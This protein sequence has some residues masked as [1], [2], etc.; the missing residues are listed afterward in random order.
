MSVVLAVLLVNVLFPLEVF[1]A[2]G[3]LF[4]VE[5]AAEFELLFGGRDSVIVT[6]T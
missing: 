3:A 1:E 4:V 2:V 5:G 6:G